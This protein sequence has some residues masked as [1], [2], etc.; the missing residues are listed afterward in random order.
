M[1]QTEP[2][3]GTPQISNEQGSIGY[4]IGNR[5]EIREI[6]GGGEIQG[7]KNHDASGMGIVYA[8]YDPKFNDT[9]ALK[10]FQDKFWSLKEN[11]DAFKN[12]ADT[13]IRLG[14]HPNIVQAWWIEVLDNRPYI[15]LEY[16]PPHEGPEPYSKRNTLAHY[17]DDVISLEQAL[18]WAIQ[19][20]YGMEHATQHGLLVHR[21]IKPDN[22]MITEQKIIKITDFGIAQYVLP[23]KGL[24]EWHDTLPRRGTPPYEA[25]ESK[26]DIR[27]D[28]Y[29]FGI[30]LHQ[31]ATAGKIPYS[32][33][34]IT[35]GDPADCHLEIDD[36]N[37]HLS[38]YV[39]RCIQGIPENRY[40]DFSTLRCDLEG[41]FKAITSKEPYRPQDIPKNIIGEHSRKGWSFYNLGLLDQALT[42]YEILIQLAP[43][44]TD[45]R[46]HLGMV[47]AQ[48]G[49][50]E[51]AIKE[52]QIAVRLNPDN[53]LAHNNL[54]IAFRTFKRY[55]LAIKEYKFSIQID[56]S[57]AVSHYNLGT[58]YLI[59]GR[60]DDA[61]EKFKKATELN[62]RYA[63]AFANLG[64]AFYEKRCFSDSIRCQ[65]EA[66][67]LKPDFSEA[68]YNLGL[69][70]E[71]VKEY[72]KAIS[73]FEKFLKY[74]SRSDP[75]IENVHMHILALSRY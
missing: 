4:K 16:I 72:V 7:K 44:D 63:K 10:T 21:D 73:A 33:L 49:R 6:F 13:W 57:Q 42:E 68:Y 18:D 29:A 27:S 67:R 2:S 39:R 53:Y 1:P 52:F 20:C 56:P 48:K 65:N 43:D 22:I 17:L 25:P 54:A 69:S 74:A 24:K 32:A 75:D 14:S 5:F 34:Y 35:G 59:Q 70:F 58:L 61:I 60:L 46:N 55:E 47:L 40:Q 62:P 38:A 64:F 19:F 51:D 28:I 31:M 12:E 8:C 26:K 23:E 11:M 66:I 71:A 3:A 30:V 15:I 50:L 9:F 45:H 37:S 36:C 41:L